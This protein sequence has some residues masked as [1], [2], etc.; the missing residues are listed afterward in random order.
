MAANL[1]Q[2]FTAF[3]IFDDENGHRAELVEQAI[4]EQSEGDVIVGVEWASVNYKDALAG[5]GKGRIL[6][7]FPLNGGI[8]AA[9]TVVR[10]D[11]DDFSAGDQVLITGSGLS[12]T[13]D[14]GYSEERRVGNAVRTRSDR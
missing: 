13:R 8:D 10:S 9:G 2:S 12:E 6:R 7:R 4:D 1:P 3:R 14:G 5:T 11:S